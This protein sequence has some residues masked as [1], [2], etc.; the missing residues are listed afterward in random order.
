MLANEMHELPVRARLAERGS[1]ECARDRRLANPSPS[2]QFVL[3][4]A[5]LLKELAN[6]RRVIRLMQ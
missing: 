1:L 5:L 3:G 6:F 2:R 4:A